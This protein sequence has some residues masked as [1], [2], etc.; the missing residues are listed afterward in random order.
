MKVR[1]GL[2]LRNISGTVDPYE[3]EGDAAF[4][5]PLQGAQAMTDRLKAD[6]ELLTEQVNVIV[7]FLGRAEKLPVR[8][9]EGAGEVIGE[10]YAG[11]APGFGIR[12]ARAVDQCRQILVRPK[13]CD[14]R[15]Q[16]ECLLARLQLARKMQGFG[17]GIEPAMGAR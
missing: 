1:C 3:K 11:E 4:C 13:H 16:L 14:L 15:R 6:T 12:K 9:K 8:H 17:L 7:Q 2:A 10:A 5:L